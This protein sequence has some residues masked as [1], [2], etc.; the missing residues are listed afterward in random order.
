MNIEKVIEKYGSNYGT[1]VVRPQPCEVALEFF[2][3]T[4]GIYLEAGADNGVTWSN[5]LLL[6]ENGWSG[7]LVEPN[8]FSFQKLEECRPDNFLLNVG[9][10]SGDCWQ[11]MVMSNHPDF[12]QGSYIENNLI[13]KRINDSNAGKFFNYGVECKS[14]N[15]IIKETTNHIDYLSLDV[16]DSEYDA[17]LGLDLDQYQIPLISVEYNGSTDKAACLLIDNGYKFHKRACGDNFY[18]KG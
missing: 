17:L 1:T 14:L 12:S 15:N 8:H 10:A 6:Q 7:I 18:A 3:D 16:E 9:L 4:T 2:G 5:T 13:K 11:T